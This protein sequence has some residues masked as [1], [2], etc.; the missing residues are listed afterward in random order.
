MAYLNLTNEQTEKIHALR[1]EGLA[2]KIKVE[3]LK[4]ECEKAVAR[5]K[6]VHE[7]ALAEKVFTYESEFCGKLAGERITNEFDA[8][9]MGEEIYLNEFLPIVKQKW[10]EL[11]GL[12]YPLNYTPTYSEYKKPYFDALREYRKIAVKFLK[13]CG[14]VE[15]AKQFAE[16]LNGYL[17]DKYAK[18]LDEL[19][20]QFISGAVKAEQE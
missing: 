9:C 16:M 18:R 2:L 3:Y 4:D 5:E 10:M 8:Y 6:D 15:V 17:P 19:N 7:K 11:Y 12:D 1:L 13:I 14:K 20:D